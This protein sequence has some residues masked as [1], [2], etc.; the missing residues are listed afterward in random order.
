MNDF[1]DGTRTKPSRQYKTQLQKIMRGDGQGAGQHYRPYLSLGRH[2]FQSRGRSHLIFHHRDRRHIELLSDL[3]LACYLVVATLADSETREQVPLETLDFELV[4]TAKSQ[5]P[6]LGTET[7][8]NNLGIKHPRYRANEPRLFTTDLVI[9]RKG[10]PCV[11]LYVKYQEELDALTDRGRMLLNVE[12]AYWK[13]R[14]ATFFVVTENKLTKTYRNLL[15]WAVDGLR[16]RGGADS[17]TALLSALKATD[18][19]HALNERLQKCCQRLDIPM[20]DAVTIFKYAI[21]AR[22]WQPHS[23]AQ[24]LD[25]NVAWSGRIGLPTDDLRK[26]PFLRIRP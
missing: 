12:R 6:A 1:L 22:A 25:L 23:P 3:E 11:A 18:S 20:V 8:C 24:E 9:F 13:S 17:V 14:G 10:V 7:I 21:L 16:W 5:I 26:V 19:T 4:Q 15:Q 2:G